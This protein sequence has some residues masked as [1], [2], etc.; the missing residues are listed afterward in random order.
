M[1]KQ[2]QGEKQR[3]TRLNGRGADCATP[4]TTPGSDDTRDA[5]LM[6]DDEIPGLGGAVGNMRQGGSL[7]QRLDKC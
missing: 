3:N 2:D 4:A 5:N 6:P 7:S 1:M